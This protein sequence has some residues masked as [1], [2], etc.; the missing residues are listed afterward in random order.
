MDQER[1][2]CYTLILGVC[3]LISA[4]LLGRMLLYQP[5][6]VHRPFAPV[7]NAVSGSTPQ[8][9]GEITLSGEELTTLL[10]AALPA[11]TPVDGVTLSLYADGTLEATGDLRKERLQKLVDGSARTLILLMPETCELRAVLSAGCDRETG[12]LRLTVEEL[13]AGGFGLPRELSG[14]LSE[15]LTRAAN[16]ALAE[17]GIRFSSIRITK[18][19]IAFSL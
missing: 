18:D 14:L 16:Q 19:Q 1:S 10:R 11:E 9:A 8:S 6:A 17:K 5:V 12:E 3:A 7:E 15:Q 13:E 4:V 2:F